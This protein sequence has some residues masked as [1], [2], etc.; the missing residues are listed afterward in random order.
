[1]NLLQCCIFKIFFSE[2]N[3]KRITN[4][5]PDKQEEFNKVIVKHL[6]IVERN[7]NKSDVSEF[8][9]NYQKAIELRVYL[10]Y[11]IG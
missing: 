10:I 7:K 8:T 11:I 5:P 2:L 6:N 9:Q 4:L 1:M 3:R